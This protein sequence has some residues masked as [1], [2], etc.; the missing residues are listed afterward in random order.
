MT[1]TQLN[2]EKD[3]KKLSARDAMLREQ[4]E[5]KWVQT[6]QCKSEKLQKV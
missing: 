5:Q 3:N 2:L 4:L 1:M 6:T